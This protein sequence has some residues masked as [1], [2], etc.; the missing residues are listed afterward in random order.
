V[1]AGTSRAIQAMPSA[2]NNRSAIVRCCAVL[3]GDGY[4]PGIS[5]VVRRKTHG[6][7]APRAPYS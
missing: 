3:C 1:P 5:A 6:A 2:L 7:M 4:G